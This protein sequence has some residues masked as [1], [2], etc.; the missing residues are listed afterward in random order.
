[1]RNSKIFMNRSINNLSRL[2]LT[3]MIALAALSRTR[4]HHPIAWMRSTLRTN[5]TS[6]LSGRDR[7]DCSSICT[8]S[9][10]RNRYWPAECINPC[11]ASK[12]TTKQQI[13][14]LL[15]RSPQSIS[16]KAPPEIFQEEL[17]LR[18]IHLPFPKARKAQTLYRHYELPVEISTNQRSS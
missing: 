12:L 2:C 18:A 7:F 17:P 10:T 14:S 13:F 8:K 16:H 15:P 1:M 9:D 3:I 11:T 5:G 4:R 6:V